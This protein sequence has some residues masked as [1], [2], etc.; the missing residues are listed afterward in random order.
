MYGLILWRQFQAISLYKFI[1]YNFALLL[2]YSVTIVTSVPWDMERVLRRRHLY[3]KKNVF[4]FSWSL[5][6]ITQW[7]CTSIG[8]CSTKKRTNDSAAAREPLAMQPAIARQNG[9]GVWLYKASSPHLRFLWKKW[10]RSAAHSTARNT[11]L[12]PYVREPRLQLWPCT[13][14]FDISLVLRRRRLYGNKYNHT[15][16]W[17][18]TTQHQDSRGS[19]TQGRSR[20]FTKH[21]LSHRVICGLGVVP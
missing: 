8:S 18:G 7:N 12:V 21:R 15:V 10:L 3:G 19:E 6:I 9:R 2:L 13:F 4:L 16:L 11:V 14:P 20:E 1:N 17:C 5:C